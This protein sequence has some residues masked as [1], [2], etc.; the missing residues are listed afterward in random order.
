MGVAIYIHI[1][2][3]HRRKKKYYHSNEEYLIPRYI[4]L[5]RALGLPSKFG[6][7]LYPCRGLPGNVTTETFNDYNCDKPDFHHAS[8]LYT[9][10][11]QEYIDY[12]RDELTKSQQD[13]NDE[14]DELLQEYQNLCNIMKEGDADGEP[15]R[16]VF[17]FDN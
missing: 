16:I 11:F 6:T 5:F 13:Y 4:Y 12:V 2:Y 17:W 14:E 9:H 1:E 8:W 3:R 10:E 7:P 15:A